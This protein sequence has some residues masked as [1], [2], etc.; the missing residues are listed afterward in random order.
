MP[1][2]IFSQI[3]PLTAA[4]ALP[5]PVIKGTRLLLAGKP[6][7]HSM[8]FITTWGIVC[9]LA[10]SAAVIWKALLLEIFGVFVNY[11]LPEKF[12]GWMHIILGFVFIGLGVKKLKL[13]IEQKGTSASQ[14]SIDITAF[15]II[16]ST[17]KTELFKL[18]NGLLLLL[19]IH[20][21]L[22]SEM[23]YNQSLIASGMISITA[24]IWVSMPLLVYF[25]TGRQR[26][27]VLEALKQWLIANNATLIIFLYL[28]IGI[29][30]LSS[31]IGEL[32]P[33]LL[34]VVFEAVV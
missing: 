14:Q 24:M 1:D 34:E 23:T 29:S 5:F 19:I 21:L 9:F 6:V 26:D 33:E 8:V 17:V 32:I 18:K 27:A 15:S 3:I 7:A 2:T 28:F 13:V 25:W 11:T 22:S 16:K 31:G 10:L 4:M 30:V 12:S 20:I